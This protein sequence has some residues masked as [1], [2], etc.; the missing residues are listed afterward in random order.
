MSIELPNVIRCI[1]KDDGKPVCGILIRAVLKTFRKNDYS[2]VFG[3]TSDDGS[4][5]ISGQQIRSEAEQ[6]L[7]LAMMDFEPLD[8]VFTGT[9]F[10][11]CMSQEDIAQAV[12]AFELYKN[13]SN[14]P[15]N[16]EEILNDSRPIPCSKNVLRKGDI[17]IEPSHIKVIIQ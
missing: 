13:V 9:V 7:R 3:P 12:R 15:T 10:I 8:T 17:S 16:Y 1:L 4:A 2:F 6:D 5:E 14:F 11:R